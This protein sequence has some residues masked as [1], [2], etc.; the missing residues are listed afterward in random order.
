MKKK[1]DSIPPLDEVARAVAAFRAA[2]APLDEGNK[3]D[4]LPAKN[5][6][7][8]PNPYQKGSR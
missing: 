7:P 5:Q 2:Y 1:K 8:I 4:A 6:R 3:K